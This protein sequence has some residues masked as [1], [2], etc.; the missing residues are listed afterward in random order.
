MAFRRGLFRPQ[1]VTVWRLKMQ[2]PQTLGGMLLRTLLRSCR[3]QCPWWARARTV[4]VLHKRKRAPRVARTGNLST[5]V[6]PNGQVESTRLDLR[7]LKPQALSRKPAE[8][9]YK[10]RGLVARRGCWRRETKLLHGLQQLLAALQD[11][12]QG[13][14]PKDA[15]RSR[16]SGS[17]NRRN[18]Q[19]LTLPCFATRTVTEAGWEGDC[20][21]RACAVA[22]GANESKTF[23]P[24]KPNG[25][26]KLRPYA[27]A[28]L[29]KHSS[30]FSKWFAV[31]TTEGSLAWGG[32]QAPQDFDEFVTT[33]AG[34]W[35]DNLS[36][37]ASAERT[38]TAIVTWIWDDATS[39]WDRSVS[40]LWL[41][42]QV[43]QCARHSSRACLF[44]EHSISGP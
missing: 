13:T 16:M 36:L 42:D 39:T 32:Q 3:V 10:I 26:A 1:H 5:K 28:H 11:K 6:T 18:P 15:A 19:T 9:S 29:R 30:Q 25:G 40:A 43:A 27:I 44:C 17:Q 12:L 38:G 20:G 37:T 8:T 31:D 33:Y 23:T 21:S 24:E 22:M 2:C 14:K 35:T 4:Q 7:P 34:V 41:K